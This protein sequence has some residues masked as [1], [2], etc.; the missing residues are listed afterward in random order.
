MTGKSYIEG[1]LRVSIGTTQQMSHFWKSF[2][3][4]D[5]I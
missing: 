3:S 2:S 4:I 5:L 1:A